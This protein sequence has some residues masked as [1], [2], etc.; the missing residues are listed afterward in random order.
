MPSTPQAR[1]TECLS[2]DQRH[3]GGRIGV[4]N[5]CPSESTVAGSASPPRE[6]C[7][8]E[9]ARCLMATS[10]GRQYRRRPGA[11]DLV[12]PD[13]AVPERACL[14]FSGTSGARGDKREPK[15]R[16]QGA[17]HE[18]MPIMQRRREMAAVRRGARAHLK[19]CSGIEHATVPVEDDSHAH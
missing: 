6:P 13:A 4:P 12:P 18:C 11:T 5:F 16:K 9:G 19:N 10:T 7:A 14:Q 17:Q 15:A 8:F 3:S 2:K 1:R